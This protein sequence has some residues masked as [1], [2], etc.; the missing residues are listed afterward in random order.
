M[1]NSGAFHGLQI[2][3]SFLASREQRLILGL[4]LHYA[5]KYSNLLC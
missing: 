5:N 2:K 3:R 1:V 4:H